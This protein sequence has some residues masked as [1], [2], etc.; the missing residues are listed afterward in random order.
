MNRNVVDIFARRS[1][2]SFEFK[3]ISDELVHEILKAAMSAPSAGCSDPWHFVTVR[4]PGML[5]RLADF[6]PN[7]AFLAEAPLAIVVCGEKER[8][9]GMEKDY[10]LMDCSA[11]MENILLAAT[12]LGLG[13][14]WLGVHPRLE[15][16]MGVRDSLGIPPEIT[17]VAIAAIGYPK[18]EIH[19][20]RTRFNSMFVHEEIW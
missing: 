6:L 13:S 14:C 8:A 18:G 1:T 16:E 9:R 10:M 11:A 15:R 3:Q 17:P 4:S 2:R 7:G 12:F 19:R 20:P 5:T